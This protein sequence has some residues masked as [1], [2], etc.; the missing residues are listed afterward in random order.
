[1]RIIGVDYGTTRVGVAVSDPSEKIASPLVVVPAE[2]A[3][4]AIRELVVE[5]GAGSIVVGL[6]VS[7]SGEEGEAAR[8][9]R[10]FAADL[11]ESTSLPVQFWDERL[12]TT[13]AEAVLLKAGLRR[14]RRRQTVDKVAA[15][16]MLQGFLDSR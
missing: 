5:L 14:R 3:A 9:A 7:F 16:I 13:S 10:A 4:E 1:M 2:Q 8:R 15:A 12:T 6:P 11:A